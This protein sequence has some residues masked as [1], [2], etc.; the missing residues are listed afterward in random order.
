MSD[1]LIL[2]SSSLRQ[3]G[4]PRRRKPLH[5][6]AR[7][8]GLI[9]SFKI[10]AKRPQR[11]INFNSEQLFNLVNGVTAR[12]PRSGSDPFIGGDTCGGGRAKVQTGPGRP[13]S[14]LAG[15][16]VWRMRR[17]ATVSCE[18]QDKWHYFSEDS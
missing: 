1:N 13:L 8:I 9:M 3:D 16:R 18:K 4:H 10:L 17:K 5:H 14:R 2:S 7:D 6:L 11:Q 12:A 15:R